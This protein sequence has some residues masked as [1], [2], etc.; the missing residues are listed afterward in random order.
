MKFWPIFIYKIWI[1]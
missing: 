1:I